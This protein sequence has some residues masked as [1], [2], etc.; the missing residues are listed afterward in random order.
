[1][2]GQL[3]R[4]AQVSLAAH[5]DELSAEDRAAAES[6]GPRELEA[7]TSACVASCTAPALS[8]RQV[9]AIRRCVDAMP[10]SDGVDEPRC[11]RYLGCL[12]EAQPRR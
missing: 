5:I 8:A 7:N 10:A 9:S 4:C 1:M 3:T 6:V 12:D 11:E 2:C